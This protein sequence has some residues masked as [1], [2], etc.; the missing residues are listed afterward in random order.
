MLLFAVSAGFVTG[1][2][3]KPDFTNWMGFPKERIKSVRVVCLS[4]S[5]L[6][7]RGRYNT[8][9]K[10]KRVYDR[11]LGSA[12][13]DFYALMI[14][15]KPFFMQSIVDADVKVF[16][17]SFNS[18]LGYLSTDRSRFLGFSSVFY[19]LRGDVVRSIR[20]EI[21][22]WPFKISAL[23]M[24][25]FLGDRSY[26]LDY[27]YDGFKRA[28]ALHVLA[29]SGLHVGIIS[30]LCLLFFSVFFPVY[31]ARP[32]SALFLFLYVFIA[33]PYPSLLRA[34]VFFA[35]TILF[36]YKGMRLI[37]ILGF[38]AVFMAVFFPSQMYSLGS[39]LSFSA[40]LGIV[41]F[42]WPLSIMIRPY[43]GSFIS[44]VFACS[45]SAFWATVPVVIIVFSALSLAGA[46]SAIFIVPVITFFMFFSV[47]RLLLSFVVSWFSVVFDWVLSFLY[48]ILEKLVYVFSLFPVIE[49]SFGYVFLA[50]WPILTFVI[51]L[52]YY[53]FSWN[54]KR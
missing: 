11:N 30:L 20:A 34:S 3:Q 1:Y 21:E 41:L 39:L 15:D 16:E 10:I 38:T 29:L 45:F 42:T 32:I 24:A 51:L 7:H 2:F 53:P 4:D 17:S 22:R 25:L 23:F 48:F 44:S 36:S 19:R 14:S 27:M 6:S 52:W 33:G 50:L 35:F 43:V 49:G 54:L 40:V 28:G 26:I 18:G 8:K 13:A 46:V 37:N 12:A 47:A 5:R 31:I 9:V